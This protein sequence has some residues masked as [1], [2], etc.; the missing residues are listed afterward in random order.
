[1]PTARVLQNPLRDSAYRP[2]ADPGVL[3]FHRE[4]PGYA[5]APLVAA[6]AL[7]EELGVG[8]VWLKLELER[9]GLPSFKPLGAS[10][11]A[12]RLLSTRVEGGPGSFEQLRERL[13]GSG[14]ELVAATDG[15]HGRA[16]ARIARM[17]GLAATILVPANLAATRIAAIEQ[18]GADVRVV[19]G[20]YDDAIRASVELAAA[21]ARRLVLSDHA[22]PG[23]EQ[24]PQWVIDGYAT[25]FLE[26]DEQLR[27]AGAPAPDALFVG[28]GVGSLATAAARHARAH[29]RPT[30]LI[31]FEPLDA[32]SFRRSAA[33]GRVVTVPGPHRSTMAGLNAGEPSTVAWPEVSRA[34]DCFCAIDDAAAE[35]GM[36][37]LA[38]L[39]IA[40]GECSGGTVGAAL[41][42][43]GDADARAALAL[44]ERSSV[45][46]LLT[47][48]VTDP[49]GYARVVG[50]AVPVAG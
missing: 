36:R 28:I 12:W 30:R 39:G 34:F 13:R 32:D 8:R 49:V 24:V 20:S 18:E 33:A 15:N 37:R 43:L 26:L 41:A 38:A 22:W 50:D 6:P 31:G 40:A 9:L 10:A 42:T 23:Y 19:D 1:M 46:L 35:D 27:D 48:G 14:L 29:A 3:A 25:I 4:L 47:E 7:A 21:D 11:A 17:L 16:V 45:L 5:V 44:D 2:P